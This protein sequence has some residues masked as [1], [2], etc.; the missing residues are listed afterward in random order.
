MG[1]WAR[2]V[3]AALNHGLGPEQVAFWIYAR[4]HYLELG[5]EYKEKMKPPVGLRL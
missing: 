4:Q 2:A 5:G 3:E 1:K